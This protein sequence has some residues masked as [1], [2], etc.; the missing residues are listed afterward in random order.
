M[1]IILAAPHA[2][3]LADR[4][5]AALLSTV[6]LGLF[7]VGLALL[8]VLPATASTVDICWRE[9]VCG[10]GFGIFQSPNNREMLSNVS[11]ERSGS[12][13]GILAVVRTFGQCFGAAVVGIVLSVYAAGSLQAPA[14]AGQDAQ[15]MA[16]AIGVA[17]LVGGV[18]G[19]ISIARIGRHD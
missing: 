3:K 10:I 13:S 5:P 16:V 17:A 19:L 18:A 8:A 7:T 1:G 12:A 11:R 2:G 9:L 15:A 14:T 4:Y 6:G